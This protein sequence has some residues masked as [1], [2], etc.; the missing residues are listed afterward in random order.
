M[1]A[2][3]FSRDNAIVSPSYLAQ[4]HSYA[5]LTITG[6]VGALALTMV[7]LRLYVRSRMIKCLGADDI[8]MAVA[9]VR[10]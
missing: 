6:C 5:I 10:A 1:P 2:L 4:N 3:L 8:V 7:L 9:M